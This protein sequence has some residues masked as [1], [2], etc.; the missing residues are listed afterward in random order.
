LTV[1][2][3]QFNINGIGSASYC[4]HFSDASIAA[5]IKLA[6]TGMLA[7]FK[8]RA[9]LLLNAKNTIILVIYGIN[10]AE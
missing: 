9:R 1:L 2:T 6:H 5:K 7:S 3:F 4:F 10:P 8:P